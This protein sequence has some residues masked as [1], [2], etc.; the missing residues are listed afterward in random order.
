MKM[1]NSDKWQVTG[2]RKPNAPGAMQSGH[3]S[4]VTGHIPAFT[5][6]ELLTV[7]A[8]IAVI[9]ALIFP[10]AGAVKRQG[11]IHTAQAEMSQ[12]ETALERYH[13]AYG[14]YPP[15]SQQ[16]GP[17]TNQLYYELVGTAVTNNGVNNYVTLDNS[18]MIPVA[19][20]PTAFG[21]N[22]G[23]FMNCN[24]PNA[25]ESAPHAQNFLPGLKPNQIGTVSSY[26]VAIS[27]L[28]TSVG[29]PDLNYLPL[30]APD[31]N[32]W[33]YVYPGV[34]NPN[35]YDLWVQLRIAGKFYLIC[36]WSS[37]VQINN[38]SVP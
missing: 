2:D 22:V 11:F 23:G 1:N 20:V 30:G 37:Q 21:A 8:V 18:A 3:G 7:I 12:I 17:L 35:S 15:G 36:N 4:R 27:N 25:D 5:L 38:G 10:V 13:S 9:A 19:S 28:V 24:K 26:G 32:P 31:V 14:F 6:I 34:N 29:G 33:R 16:Y